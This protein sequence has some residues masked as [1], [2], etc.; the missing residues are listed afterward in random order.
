ML[1]CR[2][3]SQQGLPSLAAGD[4]P[5]PH[6]GSNAALSA[7]QNAVDTVNSKVQVAPSDETVHL[8]DLNG[9]KQ[10]GTRALLYFCGLGHSIANG[11]GEKL[12]S[13]DRH[14]ALQW[15]DFRQKQLQR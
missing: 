5:S 6:Y 9:I 4:A 14:D 7:L 2:L 11:I 10:A 1:Y 13:N 12:P 8:P 15:A 3:T